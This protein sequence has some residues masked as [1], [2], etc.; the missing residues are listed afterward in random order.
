[1]IELET[2]E[3][4]WDTV[5]CS[6]VRF[7]ALLLLVLSACSSAS[8]A[9]VLETPSTISAPIQISLSLYVVDDVESGQDSSLSSQRTLAE[10]DDIAAAMRAIWKQAGIELVVKTIE[11]IASPS[12]VLIALDQ[13]DTASFLNAAFAGVITIP[14]AATINGFYVRTLGTVNGVAPLGTRTFFVTDQ[15]SVHDERVSSHE[16]GHILG[17]H[18]TTDDSG[19]LMFSGTNGMELSEAEIGTASYTAQGILDGNR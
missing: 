6:W 2:T 13:G 4:Q 3:S 5:R 14:G 9:A 1:M 11:R 8:D 19:R 17:L 18:H 7:L 15:P 12:D 16:I 10:I